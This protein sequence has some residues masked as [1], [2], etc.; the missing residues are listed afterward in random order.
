[1][2][3]PCLDPGKRAA[4]I[5]EEFIAQARTYQMDASSASISASGRILRRDT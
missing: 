2:I 1:M 4:E 3:G 5:S